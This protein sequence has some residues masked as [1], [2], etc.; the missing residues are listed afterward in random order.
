[1]SKTNRLFFYLPPE[2]QHYHFWQRLAQLPFV[3][4]IYLFGSRA[5]G[6]DAAKSDID[7][8]VSCPDASVSQWQQVLDIVEDADTLLSIDVVRYDLLK[9]GA[10]KQQIDQNKK[11]VY[12]R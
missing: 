8:A 4:A 9:N 5:R 7:L 2:I 3:K 10:F 6:D 11:V 12:A 1:M